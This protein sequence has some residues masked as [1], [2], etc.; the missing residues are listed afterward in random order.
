MRP[1]DYGS[2]DEVSQSERPKTFRVGPTVRRY[3]REKRQGPDKKKNLTIC[4]NSFTM[5]A[6]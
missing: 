2:T 4:N 3:G 5:A 6:I 1:A